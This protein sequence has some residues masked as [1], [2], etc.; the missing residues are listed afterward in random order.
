MTGASAIALAINADGR[1][2]AFFRFA[3][4]STVVA[5]AWQVRPATGIWQS[6][7]F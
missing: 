7:T 5:H 1:L 6:E 4:S 2:E 3:G